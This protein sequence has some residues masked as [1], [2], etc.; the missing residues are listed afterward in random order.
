MSIK[1][2][3]VGIVHSRILATKSGFLEVK[4]CFW[5]VERDRC[6]KLTSSA[7]CEPIVY[8]IDNL[9][10]IYIYLRPV[11]GIYLFF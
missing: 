2:S 1:T 7:I 6:V 9:A 11:K 10:T 3:S 5:G 4:K 8:N